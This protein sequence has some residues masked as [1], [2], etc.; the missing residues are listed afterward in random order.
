MYQLKSPQG[1]GKVA[2]DWRV[3]AIGGLMCIIPK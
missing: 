1:F 3:A 2:P